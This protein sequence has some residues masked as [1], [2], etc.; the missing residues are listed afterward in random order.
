MLAQLFTSRGCTPPGYKMSLAGGTTH[1]PKRLRELW[2]GSQDLCQGDYGLF[3]EFGCFFLGAPRSWL[4]IEGGDPYICPSKKERKCFDRKKDEERIPA[5]ESATIQCPTRR[6]GRPSLREI[7]TDN[8][9]EWVHPTQKQ[10]T[11]S[12][13]GMREY[14]RCSCC[15]VHRHNRQLRTS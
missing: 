2:K 3:L 15:T 1:F 8:A 11:L 9:R 12:P 6:T 13:Y 7:W 4:I 10:W 5:S 14:F